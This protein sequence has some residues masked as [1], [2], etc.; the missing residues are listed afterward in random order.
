MFYYVIGRFQF[1]GFCTTLVSLRILHFWAKHPD[2]VFGRIYSQ[3]VKSRIPLI[4]QAEL[5]EE[6]TLYNLYK[7]NFLEHVKTQRKG[8]RP[9]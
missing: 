4:R 7:T 9:R 6:V 1:F 8:A 5:K 2:S 3:I